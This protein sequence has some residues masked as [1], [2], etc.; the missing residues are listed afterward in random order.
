[1]DHLPHLFLDL[2]LVF[3]VGL[4]DLFEKRGERE[5]PDA[6]AYFADLETPGSYTNIA[7]L[8]GHATLRAQVAG[9]QAGKL[10]GAAQSQAEESLARCLEQGSLGLSTGLNEV[11]S[12]Y[13]DVEELVRL[14]RVVRRYE[15]F[16]SSHLRD[17]KFHI[18][19]AIREA[20]RVVP[21]EYRLVA[22]EGSIF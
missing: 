13:A 3:P 18:I 4:G 10:E 9:M 15:G 1:M 2:V 14:G 22:Y 12:S 17:Y 16:Y 19:E 7:A 20:L 8:T 6:A 21:G 5:W 11:P